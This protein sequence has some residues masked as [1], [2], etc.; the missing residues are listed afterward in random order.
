LEGCPAP[1]HFTPEETCDLLGAFG[2]IYIRGDSL[3]R[4]FSQGLYLLLSNSFN[5]VRDDHEE[6]SGNQVFT[7]GKECTSNR[8]QERI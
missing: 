3:M 2:G 4:Q 8:Q 6:C 1:H 5:I 7:N